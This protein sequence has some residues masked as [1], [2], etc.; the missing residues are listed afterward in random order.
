MSNST[1]A[2]HGASGAPYQY[3]VYPRDPS[4]KPGQMGNYIYA[5]I[6]N[7]TWVPVYIGQ[8]DLS[9]R[10]KGSHHQAQCIDTKSATHVHMRVNSK[11]ES[12]LTDERDLLTGHPSA[13]AP[14]GCNV[15]VGG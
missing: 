4:I 2:W 11:E 15:K 9:V 10:C 6:V 3:W 8:G 7:G 14:S 12:R 13:Y 1:V 5:K